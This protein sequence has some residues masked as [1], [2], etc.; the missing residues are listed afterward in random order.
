VTFKEYRNQI[1]KWIVNLDSVGITL[2]DGKPIPFTFFKTFLGL[3]RKQHQDMYN[4][5]FKNRTGCVPKTVAQAILFAENLHKD[6]F[7]LLIKAHIPL[8][9]EDKTS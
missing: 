4:G 1:D 8:F 9:E 3:T 7:L 2:S 6:V 5:T